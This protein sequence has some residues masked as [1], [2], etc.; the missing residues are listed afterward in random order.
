MSK[1][2]FQRRPTPDGPA[3]FPYTL[4]DE[5]KFESYKNFQPVV[6]TVKGS[7]HERSLPQLGT[8]WACCRKVA[9]NRSDFRD[10]YAVDSSVRVEL[11]FFDRDKVVVDRFGNVHVFYLSIAVD[12]LE[13]IDAC[14]FFDRA[15]PLLAEMIGT[16]VE[17]LIANCT[18]NR[19]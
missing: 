2:V 6:C 14:K 18:K 1:I 10:E 3:L 15:F 17:L 5:N 13:H 16:T 19:R 11:E 4:D 7:K 12:N 9:E 8:Y